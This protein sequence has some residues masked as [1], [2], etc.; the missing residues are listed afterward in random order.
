MLVDTNGPVEVQVAQIRYYSKSLGLK[1]G[2]LCA[3]GS[4]GSSS[5]NGNYQCASFRGL[6]YGICQRFS[7]CLE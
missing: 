1:L 5:L 6:C 2:V 4:L 7:D 3:L